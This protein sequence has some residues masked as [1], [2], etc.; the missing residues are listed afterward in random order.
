MGFLQCFKLFITP[1][2]RLIA[3]IAGNSPDAG[4]EVP[5]FS[6]CS[7]TIK[8]VDKSGNGKQ[9]TGKEGQNLVQLAHDND[10]E[11]EG[12]CECSLACRLVVYAYIR[13]RRVGVCATA[14][15]SRT[16]RNPTFIDCILLV[17]HLPRN[18]GRQCVR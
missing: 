5:L 14:F 10:I 16:R 1:G 12:A 6:E 11:L 9:V 18:L 17:Q 13:R 3:H 7:V 4:G 8:F 2:M 15:P